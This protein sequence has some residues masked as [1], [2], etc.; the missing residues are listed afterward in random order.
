MLTTITRV[1]SVCKKE[2]KVPPS[3]LKH[4]SC[5][6]CSNPCRLSKHLGKSNP[7]WKGGKVFRKGYIYIYSPKHPFKTKENYV[8]EHRLV[9]EK[10]IGRY[11]KISEVIH[12]INGIKTDNRIENLIILTKAKHNKIHFSGIKQTPETIQKRFT[13]RTHNYS[14]KIN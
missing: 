7:N 9:M 8:T 10:Q 3:S 5:N 6:Y 11:L 13:N 12:H 1:C 4:R 14:Y 2:F